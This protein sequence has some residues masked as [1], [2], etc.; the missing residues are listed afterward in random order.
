MVNSLEV[1]ELMHAS[2][3]ALAHTQKHTEPCPKRPWAGDVGK[4]PVPKD[5]GQEMWAR[6]LSLK[7][8]GAGDVGKN[9]DPKDPGQEMWARTLP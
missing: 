4:N 1:K 5:P 7:T 6:T 8:H 2:K 3:A 9:P